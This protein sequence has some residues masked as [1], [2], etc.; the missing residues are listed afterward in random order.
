ML[1]GASRPEQV[2]RNVAAADLTLPD[3]AIHE[4]DAATAGVKQA[5]GPSIDVW[6]VPPR[7]R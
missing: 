5:M 7:T 1:V 4:L 2:E 3:A 6:A